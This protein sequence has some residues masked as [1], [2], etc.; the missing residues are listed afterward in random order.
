MKV[1]AVICECDPLHHGHSWLF[2]RIRAQVEDAAIV[3]IMS[4]N[5]VQ[6]GTC[7]VLPKHARARMVLRGGADLVLELPFPYSC[8][9]AERFAQAGVQVADRLGCVDIL[10]FGSECGDTARL[11]AV[12]QRMEAP[13]FTTAY[14]AWP[15]TSPLGHGARTA[16]IYRSL[17][18]VEDDSL[19]RSPNDILALCYLRAL[20][21]EG[22]SIRPLAFPRQGQAHGSD[23]PSDAPTSATA[24]RAALYQQPQKDL[25]PLFSSLPAASGTLLQQAM[26]EGSCPSDQDLLHDLLLAYY[27]TVPE[28]VCRA[29][30]GM[31]GGLAER[32]LRAAQAS[33]D[34]PAFF[35]AIRT[36]KYTDAH[37]RRTLLYGLMQITP[38]YLEGGPAYT[39]I[40]GMNETGAHILACARRKARIFCLN[41]P[42][43]HR[44]MPPKAQEQFICNFRA[45]ALYFTLLPRKM[46]PC[47]LLRYS[48]IREEGH[49]EAKGSLGQALDNCAKTV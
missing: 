30:A 8:A 18:G 7:A 43:D 23:A 27:R 3:A 34:Y 12:A 40:L 49:R 16:Q 38:A 15:R 37:L 32:I 1:V 22:S 39:Q 46:A 19:L 14:A 24:I 45:D 41:K 29:A 10:A 9:C 36:K 42:A 5:Y 35:A 47:D 4:G 11:L 20:L 26:Q 31:Q 17:Y 48:P 2:Q 6:R 13:A 25:S 33:P 28:E 21:Q 44:R